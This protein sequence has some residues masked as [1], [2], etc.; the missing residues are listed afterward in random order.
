MKQGYKSLIIIFCFTLLFFL[1]NA[2]VIFSSTER[3]EKMSD[4]IISAAVKYNSVPYRVLSP[5]T[6]ETFYGDLTGYGPDCRGCLGITASG[7]DVRDGNIYYNDEEYG[8]IRIVAADRRFKFGTI[9]KV[10]ANNLYDYS[11]ITIVLDRGGLIKGD[12]IDL[13]FEKE[14]GLRAVIGRQ[15][16]VKYEVLRF[17]W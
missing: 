1:F 7:Y 15:N 12:V 14:E 11:F 3:V 13:L 16:N 10:T 9:I 8:P 2:M 17:G 4:T 6:L 5:K